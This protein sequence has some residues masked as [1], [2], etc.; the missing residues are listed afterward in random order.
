MIQH[1][2]KMNL[3]RRNTNA[4]LLIFLYL[5]WWLYFVYGAFFDSHERANNQPYPCNSGLGAIILHG[6]II[7]VYFAVTLIHV[8]FTRG[9]NRKDY[10]KFLIIV[11]LPAILLYVYLVFNV[12]N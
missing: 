5:A 4:S 2:H 3:F 7:L 12:S 1:Q 8:I 6:L 10:S 11:I 9:L